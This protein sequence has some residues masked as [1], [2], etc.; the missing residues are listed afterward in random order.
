MQHCE[1]QHIQIEPITIDVSSLGRV[2]ELTNIQ[3][4]IP[5]LKNLYG[6]KLDKQLKQLYDPP[7]RIY[8]YFYI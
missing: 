3:Q 2:S 1:M 4:I 8:K 5:S 7:Y 6:N